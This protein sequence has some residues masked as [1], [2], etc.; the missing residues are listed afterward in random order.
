M[1]K[2]ITGKVGRRDN[3]AKLRLIPIFTLLTSIFMFQGWHNPARIIAGP[4]IHNSAN[5]GTKYGT[6][7]TTFDCSTCHVRGS[8]NVKRVAQNVATPTGPRN[9]VFLRMTASSAAIQGV[10][11]DDQRSY[12][13][14]ASTNICEVCHHN[15][16]Y[17]Q[18]SS[19]KITAL[20]KT[21]ENRHD[22]VSC[23]DHSTGFKA[24]CDGCHGNPPVTANIGGGALNGLASPATG[25]TSPASPGAHAV[26]V[27]TEGMKCA[28]C[29][30]GTTM[31][32]VSNSIQMGFVVNNANWPGFSGS[33]SFGSFSGHAP[34]NAPYT[35]FVASAA[36]TTVN[37]SAAYRN[38]CNVY[39]HANWTGSNGTF[40]PSWT[41][42]SAQAACGSC[43]GA[44]ASQPPLT[45]SHSRHAA[46]T[47]YA[48]S[49]T[50]C[51]PNAYKGAAVNFGH[52]DGN[53][54][55]RLSSST[56]GPI[57]GSSA[58]RSANNGATGAIAPSASY[59]QCANIYCH[60]NGQSPVTYTSPTWGST[61]PA[62]CSGCHGTATSNTL[63]GKHS[64]HLN[65]ASN[66]T[67]GLG[68]G[69][70]CIACHAKTVSSN[71][72]IG[73]RSNHV[74]SFIDYSGA[75]AGG[76]ARYSTAT[77][78][79]ANIYCHSNG[80][81]SAIVFISM[82]G[83]KT[84]TGA[85]NL[86]CNGCHGRSSA[87]G[88]PDYANGGAVPATT[89]NSHAKHVAGA[90][91]TTICSDCH[92]KTASMTT[93]GRF[94]DY[95]AANYHLNG[96]PN[97]YFNSANAGATATWNQGSG[98]CNNVTCHG[99]TGSSATWG[100]TLNCQDCH[101]NGASASTA[102]FGATFWSNGSISKFQMTGYGSWA[103]KG[104]GRPL[105]NYSG[106]ANPAANFAV[107]AR[108]CEYC[109]D[110]TVGHKLS[111]N[112]FRLL[113]YS[114]ASYGRNAPCLVCHSASGAGVTVN[115]TLKKR[116]TS[117][118]IEADH[119]GTKHTTALNGGQFCWDCHDPHGTSNT[120]H[121]MVR[122]NLAQV[123]NPSTSGPT[124]LTATATVFRL[125]ATPTGTDYA[126]S[127][128]PFTGVCNVCHTTTGHYT[129]TAG[130]SHNST[131]RCT[132]CHSHVGSSHGSDAFKPT[133]GHTVPYY[134]STHNSAAGA[135]PFSSCTG[136]HTNTKS[137]S[138]PYP[139]AVGVAPDCQNCHTKAAPVGNTTTGCYSCHGASGATGTNI[140][141]P[142]TAN[143]TSF[144]DRRGQHARG[145]HNVACT[146]CHAWGTGSTKHGWSNRKKS[147]S[148]YSAVKQ[149]VTVWSVP[150]PGSG[151]RATSSGTC[152]GTPSTGCGSH[153]TSC[154]WY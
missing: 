32:T 86:G 45:G 47:G 149:K 144:P 17:H 53:V 137:A 2:F 116:T 130:D 89:A 123:S 104:H 70:N 29:H 146:T 67:L 56:S 16:A 18:Y 95:T 143:T 114:T 8:S 46:T 6:W 132:S 71:T 88:A 110:S 3:R 25:A 38:S 62:D 42:G 148:A 20:N 96:T 94:K 13:Q 15:T 102:D 41:G 105:G 50:K 51:H 77:K 133:G 83:S 57:T 119:Y 126:K 135:S 68:N 154:Y 108:Q 75:K 60:S 52:I 22:C 33:A 107:Q 37:T 61:L 43:H 7:G 87:L 81:P 10:F 98:I 80:N 109:H 39:C 115:G 106:S 136:C 40:N 134:G 97:V 99:G 11:G 153:G 54:Q 129:Q 49:C 12:A 82:T 79:C 23:H 74:N 14:N 139:Q 36:G 21:H 145:E 121:Y 101:A 4:L 117:K 120:N 30:S 150:S 140:G 26:H 118:A 85:A 142:A 84:W 111:S 151:T 63:S 59:G 28:A 138:Y 147:F 90:A 112:P 122:S 113:S 55:W 66:A 31:P 76:S 1:G 100:A 92:Q 34:L 128:T 103:S 125:S 131:T 93:A 78:S 65:P 9:V 72:A 124:T 58:Y 27:Q 35:G 152:S 73:T 69:F 24:G 127:A 48:Y 19:T 141:R 91:S 44:S 64:S 5:L